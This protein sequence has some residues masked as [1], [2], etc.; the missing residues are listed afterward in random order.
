MACNVI[1][2]GGK[3]IGMM[4]G[5]RRVARACGWCNKRH[6]KLCDQKLPEGRTCDAPMCADHAFGVGKNEDLCP[7]HRKI[8]GL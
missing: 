2:Q 1:Y 4:C 3:P 6:T 5:A 8:R 7:Q